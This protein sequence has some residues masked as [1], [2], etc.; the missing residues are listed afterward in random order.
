VLGA[1]IALAVI[2]GLPF[3]QSDAGIIDERRRL[4]RPPA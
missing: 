3:V 4:T 2:P 1:G